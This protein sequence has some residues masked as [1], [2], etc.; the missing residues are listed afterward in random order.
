[1]RYIIDCDFF[2]TYFRATFADVSSGDNLQPISK[3]LKFTAFFE[4]G[5]SSLKDWLSCAET[6]SRL[7]TTVYLFNLFHIG[8]LS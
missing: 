2:V 1:V 7:W 5:A 8:Y 3:Q 4:N 6:Y